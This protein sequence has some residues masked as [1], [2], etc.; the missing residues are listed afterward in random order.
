MR[1]QRART[2]DGLKH[3]V[4][5]LSEKKLQVEPVTAT[6]RVTE[7]DKDDENLGEEEEATEHSNLPKEI[8]PRSVTSHKS[9]DSRHKIASTRLSGD[10]DDDEEDFEFEK[11]PKDVDFNS[12]ERILAG[13]GEES[14]MAPSS[15]IFDTLLEKPTHD[16]EVSIRISSQEALNMNSLSEL[17]ESMEHLIGDVPVKDICTLPLDESEQSPER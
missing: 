8:E 2:S 14:E 13:G 5:L 11:Y 6:T 10:E 12:F 17:V 15:S 3:S 1:S 16:E 4:F 9:M 7:E